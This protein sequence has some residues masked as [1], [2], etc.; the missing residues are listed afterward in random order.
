MSGTPLINTKEAALADERR[1]LEA[2]ANPAVPKKE[3]PTF[4]EWFY[5]D[6]DPDKPESKPDGRFWIEWVVAR[7]NK[8][9]EVEAKRGIYRVHLGPA[10]G[11]KRLDEISED[12]IARFKAKLVAADLS[13]KRINNVLAVLSKALR[14]AAKV[15][16]LDSA[17]DVGLYKVERPEV[18]AW[19]FEEYARLLQAASKDREP[20]CL[21]AVCLAGEAGLRVGEVKALQWED[22]DLV[23]GTLTVQRQV[24]HGQVGTPKGRTRRVVPL[25]PTLL[26]ALKG[27]STLRR[28]H[29]IRNLDGTP[30]AD[31]AA[32]SAIERIMRRAGLP[33]GLPNSRWHKLRHSFGTHAAL[34]G[35]NPWSL[36]VWMGHKTIT[37]TLRYVHVA[38]AHRRPV[39]PVV[40]TAGAGE[41]NPDDRVLLMLG[42]RKQVE[43]AD[44]RANQVPTAAAAIE[45]A[46][47]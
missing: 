10:F 45:N 6:A 30:K 18:D 22:V 26:S 38:H 29:V 24:R 41:A 1:G 19:S 37:E 35:V 13:E 5:G 47:G 16:L 17:P 3:V 27:L 34:F 8:P 21:A 31:Q 15:R 9:S 20:E 40:L 44:R 28:G 42:A 33:M 36:M 23:A 46:V 32:R 25:T 7:K 14:Y 39:P 43:S 12:A 11:R 2:L 4:R